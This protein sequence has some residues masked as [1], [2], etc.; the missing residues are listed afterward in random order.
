MAGSVG[1]LTIDLAANITRFERSLTRA[2]R[3]ADK[4]AKGIKRTFTRMATGIGAALASFGF[5]RAVESSLEFADAIGKTADK[6]GIS[7]DALQEYRFAAEQTGVAQSALDIGIQRFTRRLGE[8]QEGTGVLAKV[9]EGLNINLKDN[10]GRWKSTDKVLG[11]YANAIKDADNSQQQLLLTFKA[12]DTEGAA[13]VNL[14]RQGEEGIRRFRSQARSLGIVMS[15]DLIRNAEKASDDLNIL[16]K[17]IKINLTEALVALAPH[18]SSAAQGIVT[19]ATGFSSFLNSFDESASVRIV[20]NIGRIRKE[21]ELAELSVERA[22]AREEEGGFDF[23]GLKQSSETAQAS[24]DELF[25]KLLEAELRLGEVNLRIVTQFETEQKPPTIDA[26]ETDRFDVEFDLAVAQF[27]RLDELYSERATERAAQEAEA[28]MVWQSMWI[29][30]AD[31]VARGIGNAMGDAIVDQRN[32]AEALEAVAKQVVKSVISGMVQIAIKRTILNAVYAK[33]QKLIVLSG[34]G[35]AAVLAS[36]WA[37]AAASVSLASFGANAA[38]AMAGITSTHALSSSLA[39][40]GQ[41]DY[42]MDYVPSD[43]SYILQR[44]EMVLDA[45]TSEQ[46]RDNAIGN[47]G[48][49]N[50]TFA[51]VIQA[52]DPQEVINNQDAIFNNLWNKFAERMNEEGVKFA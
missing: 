19:L 29:D 25:D 48:V 15:E 38:P 16:S 22:K 37:P 41:A 31:N 51:P 20:E 12:F 52:F 9:L 24:L 47:S 5:V 14:F 8:A 2:E 42:G 34:V 26:P 49:A 27:D 50:I 6:L 21:I 33:Q 32:L 13:L 39:V 17:V 11:E 18:L 40:I 46:V 30:T 45:G 28:A 7:T 43:G 10:E 3:L 36:A 35:D 4:R 23:F 1:S 44:G